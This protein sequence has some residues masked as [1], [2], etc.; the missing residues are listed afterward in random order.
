[1]AGTRRRGAGQINGLNATPWA[2]KQ[3]G[4]SKW[5]RPN[6]PYGLTR[7][8]V[9]GQIEERH[10]LSHGSYGKKSAHKEDSCKKGSG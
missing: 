10:P 9:M 2:G 6:K 8:L 3:Q 1:M 7:A 4:M 5:G